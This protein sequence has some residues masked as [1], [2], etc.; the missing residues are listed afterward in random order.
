[1]TNISDLS[2]K[3]GQ[4]KT[5]MLTEITYIFNLANLCLDF[6][7]SLTI[8]RKNEIS[9]SLFAKELNAFLSFEVMFLCL[10]AFYI[11]LIQ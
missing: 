6:I 10:S 3:R 9:L 5:E 7:F 1:M 4:Q 11:I 8:N 2:K